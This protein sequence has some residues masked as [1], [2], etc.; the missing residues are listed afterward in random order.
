MIPLT[1]PHFN[2]NEWKYVKDCLDTGW[3]SSA[4]AYVEK[5]EHSV[6]DYVGARH[7]I[8]CSSGT[9]GLQVAQLVAGVVP[10]DMVIAP[11]LTFVATINSICHAGAQPILVDVDASQWQ[12]DLDLLESFLDCETELR[13]PADDES[14]VKQCVHRSSGKTIRAI[15]P[16]HV[17][18]VIG[19]MHRLVEI[20]N[21][22]GLV[23]IEDGAEALGSMW[24]NQHA[25]TFGSIGVFS[26]NGNKIISTGGGGMLVT[27]DSEHARLAKHLTTTAKSSPN[28][29]FHDQVGYNYRMVNV[30]AAIGVAQME[31]L[32]SCVAK[33]QSVDQIYRERLSGVGDIAFQ[34][35]DPRCTPNSWLFTLRTG[36]M[37]ELAEHLGT[38][39]IQ[40]RPLWVPMNQL[41]MFA[42]SLYVQEQDRSRQIYDSG[43]SLP[44]SV[45]IT[46][47]EVNCVCDAVRDFF[48]LGND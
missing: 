3:I 40:T 23:L 22:H 35:C 21:R 12:M 4:G 48:S 15:M 25:G 38:Q 7:A 29:Y 11:N 43:L 31:N 34:G 8:A 6:A 44:S 16:V 27:D 10:G 42:S 46:L 24:Q 41:P 32:S 17:L 9:T 2:G 13:E 14:A 28:E 33:K 26:F 37:R 30:L 45:G 36:H 18:G 39:G 1:V 5:F 20:A 47:D 19:D